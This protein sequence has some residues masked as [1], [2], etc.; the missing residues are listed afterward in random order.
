MGETNNLMAML[1]SRFEFWSVKTKPVDGVRKYECEGRMRIEGRDCRKVYR[2]TG[3]TPQDA[4]RRCLWKPD[5]PDRKSG[6]NLRL[7]DTPP[8]SDEGVGDG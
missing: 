7:V 6:P 5:E 8:T 4:M 1:S 2:A 3:A